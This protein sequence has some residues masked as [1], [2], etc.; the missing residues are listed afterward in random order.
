MRP[1]QQVVSAE[2]LNPLLQQVSPGGV[3]EVA[4]LP[5]QQVVPDGQNTP[6]LQ[7]MYP[8]GTQ[9]VPKVPSQQVVPD[10]QRT[11]R[12]QH[13][14]PG[15][16]QP[17]SA[18]PEQQELSDAQP[19]G[20][21]WPQ[22]HVPATH[23][24][25]AGQSTSSQ[26]P[27]VGTQV[28][29]HDLVLDGHV[30]WPPTQML[31]PEQAFPQAPQLAASVSV[32]TQALP[33]RVVPEG[34]THLPRWQV[35]PVGQHLEP[36][37]WPVGQHCLPV[38]GPTQVRPRQQGWP[39]Q[40]WPVLLHGAA[41]AAPGR[42]PPSTPATTMPPSALST[43]RREDPPAS[44]FAKLSK[45]SACMPVLPPRVTGGVGRPP[46]VPAYCQ[47][48]RCRAFRRAGAWRSA[49]GAAGGAATMAQWSERG[50]GVWPRRW[51]RTCAPCAARP[52]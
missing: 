51:G 32:L 29:P 4:S 28:L 30:H 18:E 38:G 17:V 26:Q 36:H 12:L 21:N 20:E 37:T 46:S 31:P 10:G 35:A 23:V 42:T 16:V 25:L 6:V 40:L 19:L 2:Q 50:G 7:Q 52:A 1:S 3:Q 9:V 43:E 22:V 14:S 48:T 34:Q 24:S 47:H 8:D 27:A 41:S 39:L 13:V 45:R 44:T 49:H 33:H 11:P 15:C 5:S